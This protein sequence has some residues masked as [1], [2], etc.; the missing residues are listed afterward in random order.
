L[1]E[2]DELQTGYPS[3]ELSSMYD[4][5]NLCQRKVGKEVLKDES[6][7]CNFKLFS[8]QLKGNEG[9]VLKLIEAE[10]DLPGNVFSWRALQGLL[11][12]FARLKIFDNKIR[13][14]N[15]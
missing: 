3:L 8:P 13:E 1:F 7:K 12:R 6:G 15:A 14:S 11:S 10:T 9:E 5:I 4:I 2:L